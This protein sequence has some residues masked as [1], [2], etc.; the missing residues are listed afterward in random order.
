MR[1]DLSEI[2][3]RIDALDHLADSFHDSDTSRIAE[4]QRDHG[5]FMALYA[6]VQE[7]A[8]RQ[9]I[10]DA[11]FFR[12]WEIR[13]RYFYDYYIAETA[14]FSPELASAIDERSPNAVPRRTVSLRDSL[15]GYECCLLKDRG[16]WQSRATPQIAVIETHEH[17]GQFKEW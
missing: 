12:H 2:K 5:G 4:S 16:S 15:S 7:I 13:R 17:A 1:S 9:G 11:E 8:A 6:I 10:S 3:R 14:R